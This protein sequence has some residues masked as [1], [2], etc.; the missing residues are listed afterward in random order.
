MHKLILKAYNG[1][2][3][4]NSTKFRYCYSSFAGVIAICPKAVRRPANLLSKTVC[5]SRGK[6]ASWVQISQP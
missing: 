4:A 2:S 1:D 5:Q 6:V 3:Q